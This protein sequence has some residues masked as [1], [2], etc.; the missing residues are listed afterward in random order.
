MLYANLSF[1]HEREDLEELRANLS[2]DLQKI[3]INKSPRE[4]QEFNVINTNDVSKTINFKDSKVKLINF[5]AT[6][7][8]PC[9]EEMP[10]LNKLVSSVKSDD[11]SIIVIAVGR[12]SNAAIKDFFIR[13][14][15]TNL[16]SYKDPK[17]KITSKLNVFGLPT[18]VIIDQHSNE[19]ARLVGSADWNSKEAIE[20]INQILDH[21][22]DL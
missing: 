6:W 9:R 17:G 2:G 22:V 16:E 18:T 21:K 3:R 5:W 7:C 10:S 11:F 19:L 8:A 12:N 14:E 15:L 4:I 20:F 1:A 13:H